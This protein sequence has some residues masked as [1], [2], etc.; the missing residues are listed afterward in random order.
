MRELGFDYL[1]DNLKSDTAQRVQRPG[2][3][4]AVAI[5]DEAD[6]ALIDEAFTPMIIS[7]NP[8]GSSRAAMR[9]DRAVA[10][11]IRAQQGV[12]R[13]LADELEASN[14]KPGE[15][16]QTLARLLLAQPDNPALQRRISGN[17]RSLRRAW[18]LA[19]EHDPEMT[20]KLY[21]AVHPGNRFVTQTERGRHF[22]E[23]RLGPFYDGGD[24]G[25]ILPERDPSLMERRRLGGRVTRRLSRR[26]G[27]GNQVL[28]SLRARLLLKRDVDYLVDGD[29]VALIDPHTGRP[30]P[31]NIY[32]HGLQAA[33]E[34]KEGVRVRP[35]SETLAWISVSGFVNLYGQVSGITGTA[36]PAAGEFR[37]KYGLDV[38]VVPP[39]KPPMRVNLPAKVFLTREDKIAAVA[40]E[41]ASRHRMGQPVLAATRTVEQ[42]E[43]LSGE[44]AR[45]GISHQLLNAVT[46]HAEARIVRDAG[47]FGAV[48]VSTP[49]AGRGTDIMLEPGLNAR[50]V[51]RCADEVR[52]VLIG[53]AGAVD[54]S[55]LSIEQAA[56]LRAGL[57]A[58]GMFHTA[59][60]PDDGLRVTL[61]DGDDRGETR[62]H[63]FALGLCVIGTE[64]YDSRRVELQLRGRSG[65]Q[66]EFGLAQTFLSL[67]DRGVNLDAE[68]I[69]KLSACRQADAAGRV[70]YTGPEV[71]RRIERL[72][73]AADREGEAQRGLMQDYAAEF[74]RQTNLYHQRRQDVI[75]GAA[76]LHP[77]PFGKLRAGSNSPPG[78]DGILN[79]CLETAHRV[80]SRLAARHLGLDAGDDYPGRFARL[81]EETRVDYGLDCSGLYGTDLAILPA[82]LSELFVA[83]LER[84]VGRMG[85][86]SFLRVA[87]LLWLQVCGELWPAHIAGLRD[88]MAS[89]LLS[90]LNH[91]SAVAQY[92]RR[93]NE[94]WREYWELVD[95]E[96]LSRLIA[97]PLSPPADEPAVAVSR[98]TELLLAREVLSPG[99]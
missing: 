37:R 59:D 17:P 44:L 43:E 19:E 56:A 6:H 50:L 83:G 53:G 91:K 40:D 4:G 47:R 2:L 76:K 49:M 99:G 16:A 27:M 92:V 57:D 81:A 66:G 86:V 54:V 39:V 25:S 29:A 96:F 97:F 14:A 31:D 67:E 69:L 79:V 12:A 52:E 78:G 30:K 74:D 36:A 64:I 84:Q 3:S 15:Q 11:M 22:L 38:K 94:A 18:A 33:V 26:Y 95:A 51:Q 23:Q 61:R 20:S 85:E 1:R 13:E 62:R 21:Y 7:G 70:Y 10:E 46:T 5:F 24:F 82:E 41:V 8:T 71:A 90:S 28:Q 42:S 87:R 48:T 89:Q 77:H 32:Q 73:A 55:C 58:S 34:A 60:G 63:E 65:R 72:Q 68:G 9:A 93:S 45:Q 98:E 88:S 75:L 35:D 80:T